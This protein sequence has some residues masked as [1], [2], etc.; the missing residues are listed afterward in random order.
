MSQR[1]LGKG[2]NGGKGPLRTDINALVESLKV[3]E[4]SDLIE[5][6]QC[7]KNPVALEVKIKIIDDGLGEIPG[8]NCRRRPQ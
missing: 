5:N 8:G 4:K 6:F 3:L 1:G 7:F 2:C